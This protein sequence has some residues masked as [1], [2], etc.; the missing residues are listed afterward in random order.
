MIY[1]IIMILE[2]IIQII[3]DNEVHKKKNNMT[4]LILRKLKQRALKSIAI[5]KAKPNICK[6]FYKISRPSVRNVLLSQFIK[7]G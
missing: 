7:V 5:Q 2:N 4:I 6:Q 3:N 1:L